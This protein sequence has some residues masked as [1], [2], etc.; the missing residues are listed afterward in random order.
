MRHLHYVVLIIGFILILPDSL[1]SNDHELHILFTESTNGVLQNC[2]CPVQPLGGMARRK[3]LVDSIR[4]SYKY[5]I[6]VDAGNFLSAFRRQHDDSLMIILMANLQYQAINIGQNEMNY[7]KEIEKI[8]NLKHF[9]TSLDFDLF[10]KDFKRNVTIEIFC[11]SKKII[12]IGINHI[13][14]QNKLNQLLKRTHPS[15]YVILLSKLNQNENKAII[16]HFKGKIKCII[17]NNSEDIQ[18][19]HWKQYKGC[20]LLKA[21]VDGQSVGHM[22]LKVKQEVRLTEVIFHK[23]KKWI[24]PDPVFIRQINNLE[25]T[26]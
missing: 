1:L 9:F 4:S 8:E 23:V 26:R 10:Y 15:D 22:K 18:I 13:D 17:G 14:Q 19:G 2:E 12:L 25:A 16:D 5:V 20:H 24:M 7:F 11:H 6:L 3:T 21:G